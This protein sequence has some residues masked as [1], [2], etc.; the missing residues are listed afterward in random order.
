MKSA[1]LV[2][3]YGLILSL[4]VACSSEVIA[5][6]AELAAFKGSSASIY[7]VA[8]TFV[9]TAADLAKY[10]FVVIHCKKYSHTFGAAK[11][12]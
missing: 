3:I 12:Q 9:A 8:P 4:F 5:P 1:K 11:L 10:S 6:Q 2:I 7:E